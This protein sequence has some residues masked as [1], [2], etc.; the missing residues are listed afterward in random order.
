MPGRK[1]SRTIRLLAAA[2]AAL[3]LAVAL[4][5]L[6]PCARAQE[7]FADAGGHPVA[8]DD[9]KPDDKKPQEGKPEEKKPGQEKQ[10]EKKDEKKKEE[11]K[12]TWL[13]VLHGDVHTMTGGTLRGATILAKNSRIHAIGYGLD[14]PK[15]A[16]TIDAT[17][18]QVYPGLIA[19]NSFGVLGGEPVDYTTD[20]YSQN[21]TFA[22]ACG[23]T[24]MVSGNSA[25]KLTFGSLDGLLLRNNLWLRIGYMSGDERRRVREEMEGAREFMRRKR[26][27]DL[28]KAA[29]QAVEE[30]KPEGV[31]DG[32]LKL[33]RGELLARFDANST[34]DL[35]SIAKLVTEYGFKAVVFGAVEGWTVADELGRAGISCVVT[36]HT[37]RL[38]D[39]RENRPNG[40]TIENAALLHSHGVKV[41]VIPQGQRL[42]SDG[43]LDRDLR[44]PTVEAAFAVRGGL[45]RPAA[46]MA[47][48]INAARILGVD[49]R[50]GSLEVGK[51]ADFILLDGD[52]IDYS[53][54]VYYSVVNGRLVYDKAKEPLFRDLRPRPSTYQ[55]PKPEPPPEPKPEPKK[56]E[57]KKEEGKGE[58]DKKEGEKK[59]GEKKDGEKPKEGDKPKGEPK[60]GDKPKDPDKEPPKPGEKPKDGGR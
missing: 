9:K 50:V 41:A 45:P 10:E 24:T 1:L 60:P 13:A 23:W 26:A 19:V 39:T 6:A 40:A 49:D 18:L 53:S 56:E 29:G 12:D 48:T 15:E 46:E 3:P 34:E 22:L 25:G 8:T 43:L 54:F 5:L 59:E 7:S 44:T 21:L 37:P 20:V 47:L 2:L 51:D 58:G 27:F 11:K 33:L 4:A 42:S 16:A 36:P 17:G 31:N 35:R 30:P 14:V 38:R 28:A 52:L 57:P 55:E 32:F